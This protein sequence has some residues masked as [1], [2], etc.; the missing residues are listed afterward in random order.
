MIL[1]V[2]MPDM[3]GLEVLRTIKHHQELKDVPVLMYSSETPTR[4]PWSKRN[5]SE[6]STIS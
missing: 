4:P 3:D 1:D 2:N 5:A 6:P